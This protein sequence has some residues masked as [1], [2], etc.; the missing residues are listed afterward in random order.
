MPVVLL[1][2]SCGGSEEAKPA[3]TTMTAIQKLVDAPTTTVKASSASAPTTT[4]AAPIVI[5]SEVP[6][7]SAAPAPTVTAPP[8]APKA[9]P[10]KY[11][12]CADVKKAGAAPLCKGDPGY[13]TSLDRDEDGVACEK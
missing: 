6:A 8:A 4:T 11:S 10:V 2:T 5:T 7:P 12:S 13:S 9:P 1:L 3:P